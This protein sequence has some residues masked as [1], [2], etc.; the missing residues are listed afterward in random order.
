MLK[1]FP[2]QVKQLNIRKKKKKIK[3]F[4]S[5]F[6]NENN[7]IFPIILD[8]SKRAREIAGQ[9]RGGQFPIHYII[10][11][12]GKIS[13]S[14]IGYNGIVEILEQLGFKMFSSYIS[15]GHFT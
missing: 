8:S 5:S 6:I 12:D 11:K 3:E 9:Y 4:V 1:H 13:Y 10:D 14:Y 2:I 7:I 15:R